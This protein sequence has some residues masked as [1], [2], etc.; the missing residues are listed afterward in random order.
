MSL[1]GG[2]QSLNITLKAKDEASASI[3]RV[4]LSIGDLAKGFAVGTIA[5]DV[6]RRG[7]ALLEGV[8]TS[9]VR[10]YEQYHQAVAQTNAV[11]AS[12][13][14]AAGLTANEIIKLSKS[15]ADGTLYQDDMVLSA[16]NLLLTF[17]QISKD[18]FPQTTL[19]V[20]D[21]STALGQDLKSSAIQLG[22][23]LNDPIQ[24]INALQR[25]GVSFTNAQQEMITTM[26]K[27]GHTMEAQK[28][29]L[30]EI[31]REFGGSAKSAYEAASSITKLQKNVVDLEQDIGSGLV[32]ALNNLFSAFQTTSSGMARNIDVGK[33]VFKSIAFIGE[34][35]AATS[36]GIHSLAASF[37]NLASYPTQMVAESWASISTGS[38]KAQEDVDSFFSDYRESL[39]EQ[40]VGNADIYFTLKQRNEDVLKSWG[41]IDEEAKQFGESGPAA[42]QATAE[43]AKKAN[44]QIKKT[45]QTIAD[46]RKTLD[47]YRKDLQG[48]TSNVAQLFVDQEEKLKDIQKQLKEEQSKPLKEQDAA[49]IASLKTD[50]TKEYAAYDSQRAIETQLP[51]QVA[52]ARRRA[53]ETDF[54]RNIEDFTKRVADKQSSFARDIVYN[55]NFNDAVAGD[56]GIKRIITTV[57]SQI[58]RGAA[59]KQLAG[60]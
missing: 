34:A 4:R 53:G 1:F 22:K 10:E 43:E 25:V 14:H 33:A 49:R 11:L 51:T 47:D 31:Q 16:E 45:Q 13:Q 41:Q 30:T 60:T 29:I 50:L 40:V 23:A 57:L 59:L 19:A 12:T 5:T 32:P 3:S 36:V 46:T 24:G 39:H 7:V 37:V 44:D 28:F 56:D 27:S 54:E 15:L 26:V 42:Y 58:D 2:D 21:M 18:I 6:F 8:I 20:L 55:I 48:E 9:S 17:T 52:E 35:A 38:L